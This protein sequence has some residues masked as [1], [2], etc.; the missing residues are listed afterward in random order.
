M[1]IMSRLT[2]GIRLIG[3]LL[4]G[5]WSRSKLLLRF[6]VW[7]WKAKHNSSL[8]KSFY[9][10]LHAQVG[11]RV[12]IEKG[13]FFDE[14][15]SIGD[16]SYINQNS[17]VENAVIGKFCSIARGVMFGPAEHDYSNISTH[18]FWYQSFYGFDLRNVVSK[19]LE[20]KRTIISD[21]VWIGCNVVVKRGVTVHT[22]AVIG[23]GS[24]VTRDVGAYEIWGGIR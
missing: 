1:K 3:D 19:S 21:D 18:P 2:I 24:V 11:E 20:Y 9:V 14:N 12:L 8:I 22:G 16:C 23:A 13:V 17:S 15:S 7:Q 4:I 10:S 5:L 6:L